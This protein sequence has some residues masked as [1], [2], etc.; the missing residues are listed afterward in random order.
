MTAALAPFT[1]PHSVENTI[2]ASIGGALSVAAHVGG[3]TG[4]LLA[5]A[6][7]VAFISG[8]DLGLRVAAVVVLA[9][10]ALALVPARP[11]RETRSRLRLV[12]DRG[13]AWRN[14]SG[15][16]RGRSTRAYRSP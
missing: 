12:R 13:H 7:R 6:A 14:T 15:S 11:D 10:C 16:P 5:H 2:T 4:A 8:S 1:L 3:S 9:G